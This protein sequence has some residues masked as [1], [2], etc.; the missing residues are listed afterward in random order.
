MPVV[1]IE[2]TTCVLTALVLVAG[3][4]CTTQSPPSL[5]GLDTTDGYRGSVDSGVRTTSSR[6]QTTNTDA[7]TRSGSAP[8]GRLTELNDPICCGRDDEIPGISCID[9]SDG[10]TIYGGF[11]RCLVEGEVLDLR[12]VGGT[13]CEGL[14]TVEQLREFDGAVEGFA[15][16]CY[17]EAEGA[18]YCSACGDGLCGKVENRCNCARDCVNDA[19]SDA[20]IPPEVGGLTK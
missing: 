1:R 10:G 18:V 17:P 9:L 5:S 11:G 8:C 15:P 13:C 7:E 12:V 6:T 3:I 19:G 20:A 2:V 14:R 16:G 4:A